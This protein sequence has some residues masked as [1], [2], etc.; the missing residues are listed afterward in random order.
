MNKK[1][2]AVMGVVTL[3]LALGSEGWCADP[4]KIGYIGN[5]RLPVGL[6]GAAATQIAVDEINAEGG[7]LGRPLKLLTEDSKGE[8]TL[9]AA[10]YKK[11]VL[12]D[13]CLLVYTEG[14]AHTLAGQEVGAAIFKEYPHFQIGVWTAA[15][16]PSRRVLKDY[17]KYKFYFRSHS[18][19]GTIIPIYN[20]MY[21]TL[22]KEAG[23]KK[24]AIVI[25]EMDYTITWRKGDPQIG[26]PTLAEQCKNAGFDVVYNV[27]F[28]VTEKMFLPMLEKIAATGAQ[29]LYLV[30]AYADLVTLAKQWAVSP[31]KGVTIVNNGGI[32]SLGKSFWEMTEGSALGWVSPMIPVSNLNITEK[33]RP[34]MQKMEAKKV[35]GYEHCYNSYDVPFHLKK[36][37]MKAG[38]STNVNSIIKAFEEIESVGTTGTL[39]FDPK[40]HNRYYPLENLGYPYYTYWFS[41]YQKN[42]DIVVLAPSQVAEKTNPT[43]KFIPAGQLRAK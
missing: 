31:T 10:A 22:F 7:I 32:A 4:I 8:V 6:S 28:G 29:A 33:T 23:F 37:M 2:L 16:D 1:F 9:T 26:M 21:F 5:L 15:D 3:F 25:E 41:Q 11:L 20:K 42:C 35:A 24:I 12:T 14:S 40:S 39:K 38:T 43:K 18:S 30:A 19:V 13:G 34:F 27:G 17:E 36:A